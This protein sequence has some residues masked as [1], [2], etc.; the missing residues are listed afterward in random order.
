V[1]LAL[2][3]KTKTACFLSYVEYR[4]NANTAILY[5]HRII[6]RTCTQRWDWKRKSREEEK[7]E[8]KTVNKYAVQHICT[9]TRTQGNA[10][11]TVK[12]YRIGRKGEEVQWRV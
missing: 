6:C 3:R 1:K 10:L 8:R 9:G 7:K 4:P 5:I 11:K 12:Q 2:L